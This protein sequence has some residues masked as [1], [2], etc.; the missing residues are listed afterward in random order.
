M[1]IPISTHRRWQRHHHPQPHSDLKVQ[2]LNLSWLSWFSAGCGCDGSN[3]YRPA[4]GNPNFCIWDNFDTILGELWDNFERTLGQVWYNFGTTLIQFGGNF[5]TT[6]REL[7]YNFGTPLP[8]VDWAECL[9]RWVRWLRPPSSG[10]W[11]SLLLHLVKLWYIFGTT[12]IQ[13]WN[14]LWYN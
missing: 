14:K 6:L 10:F 11:K 3:H 4:S 2:P 12:L 8:W 1:E 13:F 9:R 7:W 5:D